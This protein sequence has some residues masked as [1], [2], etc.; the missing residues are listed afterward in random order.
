MHDVFQTV[1]LSSLKHTIVQATFLLPVVPFQSGFL[2]AGPQHPGINWLSV[3]HLCAGSES[4]SS[5][6][7]NLSA[8]GVLSSILS[9]LCVCP[10]CPICGKDVIQFCL[11]FLRSVLFSMSPMLGRGSCQ[12]GDACS[13]LVSSQV[14]VLHVALCSSLEDSVQMI[15]TTL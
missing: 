1:C 3:P 6:G 7:S 4:S 10:L 15:E 9:R 8:A 11:E 5:S 14:H 13:C 2:C 12:F